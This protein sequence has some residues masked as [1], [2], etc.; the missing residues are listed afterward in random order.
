MTKDTFGT[1]QVLREIHTIQTSE[2]M[3]ISNH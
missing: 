2:R 1:L 3:E